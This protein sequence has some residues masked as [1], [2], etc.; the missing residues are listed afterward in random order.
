VRPIL[1]PRMS[2]TEKEYERLSSGS[3]EVPPQVPSVRL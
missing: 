2:R 3:G 1:T